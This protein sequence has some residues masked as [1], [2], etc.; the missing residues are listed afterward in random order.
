MR[1]S[2]T[3]FIVL[4]V[5]AAGGAAWALDTNT[6]TVNC[7]CRRDVQVQQSDL[8]VELRCAGSLESGERQRVRDAQRSGARKA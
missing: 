7:Q 1:K 5:L 6:L 4:A 8:H 3:V 2:M